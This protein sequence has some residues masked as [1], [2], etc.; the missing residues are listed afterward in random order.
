MIQMKHWYTRVNLSES[1][2]FING[3]MAP[4][5]Q[6]VYPDLEADFWVVHPLENSFTLL[7]YGRNLSNQIVGVL[8]PSEIDENCFPIKNPALQR[9]T[10]IV[11]QLGRLAAISHGCKWVCEYSAYGRCLAGKLVVSE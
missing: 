9:E 7:L 3:E 8:E 10:L 11:D 1:S 5:E 2:L 4:G 6:K